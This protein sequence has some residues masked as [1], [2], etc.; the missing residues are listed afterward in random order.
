V[1]SWTIPLQLQVSLTMGSPSITAAVAPAA[2]EPSGSAASLSESELW[3]PF[4]RKPAAP[5]SPTT[6][7]A[8]FRIDSLLQD[9]FTWQTALS[10]GLASELAYNPPAA[11]RSQ[12]LAWGF[13]DCAFVEARAAQGFVASSAE[14]VLVSFRGTEST[15]DWLSN[16]QVMPQTVAGLGRVHAGFWGQFS[17]LQAQLESRLAGREQVP[18]VVTGHSL[19]GAIAVLA[20]ITWAGSYNLRALYTYGQPAVA[21]GEAATTIGSTLAGRYQRLVNDADIVPRVPPGYR[22]VGQLLHF[23]NQG[24]VSRPPGAATGTSAGAGGSGRP[25][26]SV[27]LEA[28]AAEA[29]AA[30]MLADA[31]F[32]ALQAR[33]RQQGGTPGQE[34]ATDMISDHMIPRYLEQI[35]RQPL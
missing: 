20:A 4:A 22:H 28:I 19:G 15:S 25:Q 1:A 33:L 35:R 21:Q 24:K 23:D 6:G 3:N 31:E 17:A 30:P 2:A 26:E 7:G 29:A 16:L 14:V 11:V 12:A 8:D 10:L 5:P 32:L 34:G 27:S 18:L 9:S 13:R